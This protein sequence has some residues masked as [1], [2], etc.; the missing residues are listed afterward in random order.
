METMIKSTVNGFRT[1]EIAGTIKA[2]QENPEIAS[3]QFRAR[4]NG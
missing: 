3:F 4:K 1:E 2:I